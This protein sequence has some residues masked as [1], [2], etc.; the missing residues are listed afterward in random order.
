MVRVS[1]VGVGGLGCFA[2]EALARQG[3]YALDLYDDD[4]VSIK[5]LHRQALYTEEDLG[6]KK[7]DAA[8]RRIHNI[9][10]NSIITANSVRLTNQTIGRIK[11]GIVL[12]CSDNL[13]TGYLLNDYCLSRN[14]PLIY[15]TV[16]GDHGFIKFIEK[17]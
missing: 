1:I 15:A 2:C 8:V 10:P 14:L 3:E 16:A 17:I 4:I 7:V 11:K 5:D 6:Q 13:K 9:N 12:D